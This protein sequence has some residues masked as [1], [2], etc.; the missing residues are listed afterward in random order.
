MPG[1]R[2]CHGEQNVNGILKRLVRGQDWFIY[3]LIAFIYFPQEKN[4]KEYVSNAILLVNHALLR[5]RQRMLRADN[6]SAIVVCFE[7]YQPS[8]QIMPHYEVVYNLQGPKCGSILKSSSL[9][10]QVSTAV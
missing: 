8:S 2:Q 1:E 4:Q 3:I 5:W 7:P 6:T 9:H 10:T